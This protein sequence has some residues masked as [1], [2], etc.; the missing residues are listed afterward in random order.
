MGDDDVSQIS[1]EINGP[2]SSP[3][4]TPMR[5]SDPLQLWNYIIKRSGEFNVFMSAARGS[6]MTLRS[7]ARYFRHGRIRS[8]LSRD[9]RR[10]EIEEERRE[11]PEK[12]RGRESSHH[13]R[14]VTCVARRN[15]FRLYSRGPRQTA[16]IRF[17][18]N[19]RRRSGIY[20]QSVLFFCHLSSTYRKTL[21]A[22]RRAASWR[23]PFLR[24]AAVHFPRRLHGRNVCVSRSN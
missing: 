14:R 8:A 6:P 18:A 3:S 22:R 1:Y 13:D 19:R 12:N 2:G 23:H 5:C 10:A 9:V 21:Y 4:L 24:D 7:S 11:E 16:W 15:N 20:G 17:S